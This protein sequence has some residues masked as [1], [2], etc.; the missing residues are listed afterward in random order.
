MDP[1][2]R[3]DGVICTAKG[4]GRRLDYS[5]FRRESTLFDARNFPI[6]L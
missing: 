3:R 2:L 4:D 1:G 6:G 5:L